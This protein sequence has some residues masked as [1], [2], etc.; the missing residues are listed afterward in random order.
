MNLNLEWSRDAIWAT[1]YIILQE[2]KSLI[3]STSTL[4]LKKKKRKM[5]DYATIV[6]KILFSQMKV[7]TLVKKAVILTFVWSAQ[8]VRLDREECSM[9]WGK[10]KGKIK[11]TKSSSV[12]VAK[13]FYQL[14]ASTLCTISVMSV[15]SMFATIV[16]EGQ[17]YNEIHRIEELKNCQI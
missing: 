12:I 8:H 11:I 13:L 4:I 16:I 15:K 5:F 3:E 6:D 2:H 7:R 9:S 10:D 17:R 14:N 1:F